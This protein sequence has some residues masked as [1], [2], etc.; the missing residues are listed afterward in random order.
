M[1]VHRDVREPPAELRHAAAR[2]RVRVDEPVPVQVELVVAGAW[3]R[4][5]AR[6]DHRAGRR[7]R[8][9]RASS[10]HDVLHVPL[11]AVGVLDGVDEDDDAVKDRARLLVLPGRELIDQRERR[12]RAGR[13]VAVHRVSEPHDGGC[14]RDR[15]VQLRGGRTARVGDALDRGEDLGEAG[16]VRLAR[17]RDHHHLAALEG[18]RD[19]VQL[20]ARAGVRDR[21]DVAQ[22]H[23][24]RREALAEL[25]AEDRA[26]RRDG[27]VVRPAR[28]ERVLRGGGMRRGEGDERGGEQ[29][30]RQG[31]HAVHGN[32]PSVRD[33]GER[34]GDKVWRAAPVGKGRGTGSLTWCTGRTGSGQGGSL[35]AEASS[36]TA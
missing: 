12:L 34:S 19:G 16:V 28:A 15:A 26:R 25:V 6:M 8:P 30:R 22:H 10:A 20:D 4:P 31:G 14:A 23:V 1:Q 21:L 13:L 29:G 24:V 7:L 18:V 17:R 11:V 35:Y 9:E 36:P 27:R 5:V 2:L 3:A 32:P 33:S